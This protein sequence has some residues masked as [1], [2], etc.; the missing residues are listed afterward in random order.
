MFELLSIFQLVCYWKE[1][2]RIISSHYKRCF[3]KF[4]QIGRRSHTHDNLIVGVRLRVWWARRRGTRA[5]LVVAVHI[6]YVF[7]SLVI[8]QGHIHLGHRRHLHF[9]AHHSSIVFSSL[10]LSVCRKP[11]ESRSNSTKDRVVHLVNLTLIG[12]APPSCAL[13]QPVCTAKFPSAQA[14]TTQRLEQPKSKSTQP[15][16]L[17]RWSTL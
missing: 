7:L 16:H 1:S 3:T 8:C 14:R 11:W 17:T 2:L 4:V 6:L 15:T 5:R 10:F 9:S 12:D 13:A